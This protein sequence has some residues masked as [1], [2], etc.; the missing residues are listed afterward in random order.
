[1][2]ITRVSFVA[3]GDGPWQIVSITAVA[4]ATL[5]YAT[6][7]ARIEGDA[8]TD[9]GVWALDG[10]RSS[11]R[12]VSRAE[13]DVLLARSPQLGRLDSRR[14]AL[15]AIR[16]S[17]AW[18]ALAQDERRRIF[19]ETSHHNAIG[20]EFL[21]AISRRLYHSRE[22]GQP[23]DFLTWFEFAAIDAPAF[24]VLVDRLRVSE[25]WRYV[26]REVDVRVVRD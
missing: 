2:T 17:D 19:E 13:K 12:Y 22:L 16:K 23:F 25:E 5:P 15:I 18:W 20:L 14:A 9:G 8:F 26:D 11:D 4:G 24:D 21:P 3:G 6:N 7:L 1:M 10:V